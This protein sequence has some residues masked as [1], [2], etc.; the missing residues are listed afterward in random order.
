MQKATLIGC[1]V[2][3]FSMNI[4]AQN[5]IQLSIGSY[6]GKI[7]NS[8]ILSQNADIESNI[9]L[10]G[11]VGINFNLTQNISIQPSANLI[12][13]GFKINDNGDI[14][15][16]KM[17]YIDIPVLLKYTFSNGSFSPYISI[18]PS[19]GVSLG[20]KSLYNEGGEDEVYVQ[21]YPHS[22]NV[23]TGFFKNTN[24]S[25]LGS[26]G[27]SKSGKKGNLFLEAGYQLGITDFFLE[28]GDDNIMRHRG[29]SVSVGYAFKL[30]E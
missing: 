7:N 10:S 28:T 30:A 3:L 24:F 11:A 6:I 1:L 12:Q 23:N 25:I 17:N 18:G 13:K 4:H 5:S 9:G 29:I 22:N 21:A 14:I 20:T 26:L 15:S 16:F 27:I 8:D 19:L 2:I